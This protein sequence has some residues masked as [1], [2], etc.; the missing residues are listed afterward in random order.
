MDPRE[1]AEKYIENV[2]LVQKAP[3]FQDEEIPPKIKGATTEDKRIQEGTIT[4]DIKYYA[5]APVADKT[6]RLIIDVEAQKN[7]H[8]GYPL[9][10]RGVFNGSRMLSSQHGTEFVHSQYSKIIK[11]VSIWV[12]MEPPKRRQNSITQYSIQEKSLIG[13]ARE[14]IKNYDLITVI[15]IC[16]G[17]PGSVK[18]NNVQ[19]LLNVLL[20]PTTNQSE[21]RRVLQE[22]FQI[23]M[24]HQLERRLSDMESIGMGVYMDGMKKGER[25][26]KKK[27][28]REGKIE[29]RK[30]G[31]K[32]GKAEG[33]LEDI[34]SLMESLGW[35]AEQSMLALKVPEE[36]WPGYVKQLNSRKVLSTQ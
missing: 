16:L 17:S 28:R 24:T 8:P 6:I 12:C 15:M 10:K 29:G 13:M 4:F 9:I 14:K 5:A 35:T 32:E 22:D 31:R 36:E 21:K 19:K 3:V 26:G 7:Y 11:V 18:I 23:P 2:P 34:Y 33:R 20:S 1:I 27:G 25:K 30:E